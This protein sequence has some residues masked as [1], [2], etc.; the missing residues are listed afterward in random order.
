[1][2]VRDGKVEFFKQEYAKP[3]EKEPE[4]VGARLN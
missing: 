2:D 4:P 3:P 1:V